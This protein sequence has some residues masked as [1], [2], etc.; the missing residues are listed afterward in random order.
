FS[1][2][3][4]KGEIDLGGGLISY[5]IRDSK[6]QSKLFYASFSQ[7]RMKFQSRFFLENRNQKQ[8]SNSSKTLL[9][10]V[11][12]YTRYFFLHAGSRFIPGP[13]SFYLSDPN[14][15]SPFSDQDHGR[16][17]PSAFIQF[18][19]HLFLPGFYSKK[20]LK[21]TGIF[22]TDPLRRYLISYHP[23][24]RSGNVSLRIKRN[25]LPFSMYVDLY[26]VSKTAEGYLLL[27]RKKDADAFQFLFEAERKEEWDLNGLQEDD[28]SRKGK[29]G[30]VYLNAGYFLS[31]Y[32]RFS[33]GA[34]GKDI[35]NTGYRFGETQLFP[36]HSFRIG[37]PILKA[38]TYREQ[39]YSSSD[40]KVYQ[41]SSFLAGW[42]AGKKSGFSFFLEKRNSGIHTG[43]LQIYLQT[44]LIFFSLSAVFAPEIRE[45]NKDFLF[46]QKNP[47]QGSRISFFKGRGALSVTLKSD[48]LYFQINSYNKFKNKADTEGKL[49]LRIK[50]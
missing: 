32:F 42:K 28:P 25:K 40:R 47:I 20:G 19:P 10:S 46:I 8:T 16:I 38:R 15:I 9:P 4:L 26:K 29:S 23:E 13:R 31:K 7:N 5:N 39:N 34:A 12:L 43:E 36:A 11:R 21:K 18:F 44:D 2:H 41:S 14:F 30:Q 1:Y 33:I 6:A 17:L 50:F 49:Y 35:G 27:T 45:S 22:F 48:F 37:R 24:D 3:S